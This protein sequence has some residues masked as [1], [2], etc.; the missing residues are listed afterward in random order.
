MT[1]SHCGIGGSRTFIFD[2]RALRQSANQTGVTRSF[3]R[4]PYSPIPLSVVSIFL[5]EKPTA[6]QA[7]TSAFASYAQKSVAAPAAQ[8]G[9]AAAATQE[10]TETQATIVREAQHGDKIAQR[11]LSQI[12][13][14]GQQSQAA[15]PRASEPG[16]GARV[17]HAA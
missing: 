8:P 15:P 10:A 14:A 17:D 4:H 1:A 16:K 11:K 13:S 6:V 3:D 12:Q 9:S 5:P 2:F 7:I